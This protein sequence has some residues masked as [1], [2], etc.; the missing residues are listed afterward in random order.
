MAVGPTVLL[1]TA[2]RVAYSTKN[3]LGR[4]GVGREE[5]EGPGGVSHALRPGEEASAD[6]GKTKG[7]AADG[8][9]TQPKQAPVL[10]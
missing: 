6:K 8:T 2:G 10:I 4:R 5:V 9:R 1:E 3:G 7:R